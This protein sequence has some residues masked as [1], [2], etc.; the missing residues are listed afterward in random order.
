MSSLTPPPQSE[1]F[2]A[3]V[4]VTL[5]SQVPAPAPKKTSNKKAAALKLKTETKNKQLK[6]NFL[7]Q[8]ENYV[9]LMNDVLESHNLLSKY[10]L[11]SASARFSMHV[12]VPPAKTADAVDVEK[13]GEYKEIVVDATA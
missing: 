7:P 4:T 12:L 13:F 2:K 10:S 3:T 5:L 8:P 6:F 1:S 9:K 11:V